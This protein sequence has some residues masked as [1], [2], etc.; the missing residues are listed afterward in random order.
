MT[1]ASLFSGIGGFDLA[2]E[3][4]GWENAFH[5]EWNKF[6]QRILK[7][8]WPKATSYADIRQTD[9]FIW[10]GRIDI[11]T[12][13]FPCQPYSLAGKRKGTADPRHLWTEMLR[14]IREIQPTYV[15]AENVPGLLNWSKG[16]VFNQVYTDLENE[17]YQ[18]QPVL[19]PACSLNAPHKRERIWFV[20]YNQNARTESMQTRENPIHRPKST[21]HP[22]RSN[23]QRNGIRKEQQE[24]TARRPNSLSNRKCIITNTTSSRWVQNN[25]QLQTKKSQYACPNWEN[26]PTQSPVCSR[27]DGLSFRSHNETFYETNDM[28]RDYIIQNSVKENKIEVDVN[29]GK[30]YSRQIRGSEGEKIELSGANCNGYIVHNISFN[31]IKKSCRAHQ[32]VWISANGV[33]NRDKYV[34]DHKNRDKSDNRLCNLRLATPS[35]NRRNSKDYTGQF[36]SLQKEE[37]ALLYHNSDMSIKELSIDLGISKSRIGQ[38]VQEQKLLNGITFPQWRSESIKGYGNAIVPQVAY[39]IFKVINK[40]NN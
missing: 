13:G 3:W 4:M 16:M 33:Y 11:L 40:L 39:E 27:N 8:Y 26:F 23:K 19:I 34:I 29:S 20:A 17:G 1:H 7:Y 30:I 6:G 32:I 18:I 25:I 37:I 28:D 10:R 38:I 21:P 35:Q 36:T 9:F 24:R 12:G 2:S 15:V 31:G 14:A 22:S 5:C